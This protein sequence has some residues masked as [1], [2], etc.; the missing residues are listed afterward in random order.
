MI[1]FVLILFGLGILIP[2]GV[3][4]WYVL[5]TFINNLHNTDGLVFVMISFTIAV[6]LMLFMA[7]FA[8]IFESLCI[9]FGAIQDLAA[10]VLA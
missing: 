2:L 5:V 9:S 3:T 6:L 7:V 8:F 4:I 1:H 10:S